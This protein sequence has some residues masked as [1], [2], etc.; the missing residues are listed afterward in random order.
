MMK[1]NAPNTQAA[2]LENSITLTGDN[3]SEFRKTMKVGYYKIF[4][5]KRTNH[6]PT[7]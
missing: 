3:L 2:T 5:K 4:R 7:I 6:R 1:H